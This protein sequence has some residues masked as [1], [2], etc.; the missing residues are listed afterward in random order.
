MAANFQ[1]QMGGLNGQMMPQQQQQQQQ[2]PQQR[3]QQGGQGPP[4]NGTP[5]NQLQQVIFQAL[6]SQ[7]GVLSGWQASVLIQERMSTVL[8]L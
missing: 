8:N 6:H 4:Q 7:T 5:S 3:Q 2:Q 1:Q